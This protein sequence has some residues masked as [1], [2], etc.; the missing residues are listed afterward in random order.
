MLLPV[1]P[2]LFTVHRSKLFKIGVGSSS[3]KSPETGTS[4]YFDNSPMARQFSFDCSKYVN[5]LKYDEGQTW[6]TNKNLFL[7]TTVCRAD[8]TV[9]SATLATSEYHWRIQTIY[10][11]A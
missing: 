7:V 3:D 4:A 1:N 9:S 10:K 6:P 8:G 5:K 11:D 2:D